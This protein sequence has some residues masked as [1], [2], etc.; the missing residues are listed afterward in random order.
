MRLRQKEKGRSGRVEKALE[1]N[2]ERQGQENGEKRRCD[3]NRRGG[4]RD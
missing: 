3:G 2:D 4:W 1:S